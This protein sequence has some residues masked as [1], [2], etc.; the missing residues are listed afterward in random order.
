MNNSAMGTLLAATG[1]RIEYAHEVEPRL[2]D[3]WREAATHWC[4][5]SALI[6]AQNAAEADAYVEAMDEWYEAVAEVRASG[7]TPY[8]WIKDNPAPARPPR[9]ARRFNDAFFDTLET[10]H[11]G[12][13]RGRLQREFPLGFKE[14]IPGSDQPRVYNMLDVARGAPGT[15]LGAAA[16]SVLTRYRAIRDRRGLHGAGDA[17]LEWEFRNPMNKAFDAPVNRNDQNRLAGTKRKEKPGRDGAYNP[18]APR[19]TRKWRFSPFYPD[20]VDEDGTAIEIKG[21][22]DHEGDGQFQKYADASPS[23]RCIVVSAASCDPD[24]IITDENGDC[25]AVADPNAMDVV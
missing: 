18:K 15:P 9:G 7:A 10:R 20:A 8:A 4:Q 3:A 5:Q 23:K 6:R 1:G 17:P 11:P 22:G 2:C 16:D 14:R 12:R 21:P 24:K 25:R 19:D 13:V